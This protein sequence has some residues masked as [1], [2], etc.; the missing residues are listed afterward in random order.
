MD[1]PIAVEIGARLASQGMT[2]AIAESCTGGLLSKLITDVPGASRYFTGAVC[3]YSNGG[4]VRLLS[5]SRDTLTKSGAVS[6]EVAAEMASGARERMGTDIGV[7]ITGVAGPDGATAGKPVGLVFIAVADGRGSEAWRHDFKGDRGSVRNQAA[8]AALEHLRDRVK[9]PD[10]N[11]VPMSGE[12]RIGVLASG[13]GTDLQ[14][15]LDACSRGDIPGKVVVVVTNNPEAKCLERARR[16]GADAVLVDHRGKK[17]EEHEREVVAELKARKVELV[18]LAGYLRMF[19][20]YIVNE[21]RGRMINVHP[22]L[23][24]LFGGKGMHGIKVHEAVLEA[25][26]KVSGATVHFVDESID[27]GPIIAQGCV[28]VREG[29]TAEDLQARVLE[30]E[31][32]LLPRII[33][34][35]AN[36]K[37]HLEGLKVR[38]ESE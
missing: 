37:V 10:A 29:D 14:S 28:S 20:P 19:T 33:A 30:E 38:V 32:R 25:G 15:I 22:A 31:H 23:L 6:A 13:S 17:R 27:G 9:N 5:V 7:A 2:L 24:P 21:F 4:K 36:G 8:R 18:V 11:P 1:E 34:L 3:A 26:C 16:Y 35:I 12:F